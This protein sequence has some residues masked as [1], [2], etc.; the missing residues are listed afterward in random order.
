VGL[1]I[2]VIE[3]ILDEGSARAYAHEGPLIDF[4][5]KHWPRGFEGRQCQ[6]LLNSVPLLVDDFDHPVVAE[7]VV[8]IAFA[9]R[10]PVSSFI[11][12]TAAAA[13]AGSVG[14]QLTIYLIQTVLII[15]ASAL[16]TSLFGQKPPKAQGAARRVYEI[17]AR[18]N[19]PALGDVV[20]EHFGTSWF[21]PTYAAQPYSRFETDQQFIFFI[22]LL[23]AGEIDADEIRIGTTPVGDFPPGVVEYTIFKPADHRSEFGVIEAATGIYEDVIT[24]SEVQ[25]IDLGKSSTEVFF[26]RAFAGDNFYKGNEGSPEI[27]IGDTVTVLGETPTQ[28]NH[29]VVSTVVLGGPTDPN[30]RL[31]RPIVNDAGNPWYQL[32][33]NDDGWRGWFMACPALK[34]TNRI[35][36]DFVFPNGLFI[37]SSEGEFF[38]WDAHVWAEVQLVDEQ[39]NPLAAPQLYKY[40][41]RGRNRNTKRVTEVLYLPTGRYRVRVKREDRDDATQRESSKVLWTALRAFAVNVGGSFAYGDVTLIAMRL[42]ATRALADAATGRITVLGTRV[43]PT[44]ASD[45]ATKARTRNPADAFAQIALAGGDSQGLDM[46]NLKSLS[47]RW[48]G[49]NGFNHRFEDQETVF[50]ALSVCAGNVRATPSAYARQIGMRLDRAQEFDKYLI[51]AQQMLSESYSL[52]FKLR[53]DDN[54]DGYRVEYQDPLSTQTLSVLWPLSAATPEVVRL[55][56]CTDKATALAQAKYLWTKRKSLRRVVD[57][58]TELDAHCFDVG[59]RIA[60][61]H[62][63]VDWVDSARI[64]RIDPTQRILTIDKVLNISGLN[65]CVLRSEL[66]EPSAQIDCLVDR[67]VVTLLTPPPFGIYTPFQGREGTTIAIGTPDN[68]RSAY[69]VQEISP[70]DSTV[71]VKAIG[72]DGAE[73]AFVI[74]GEIDSTVRSDHD[75]PDQVDLEGLDP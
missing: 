41:Y 12:A 67:N 18:Q 54:L 25:E 43:L 58:K 66:G 33:K 55:F 40:F 29:G 36:L 60:V 6:V 10:D 23:G 8:V 45:F 51:T 49:I 70:A 65:V 9:P 20:P 22:M 69:I 13:A 61:L 16:I 5:Q 19:Q 32:V 47:A 11:A 72:Y 50:D 27:V 42:R 37:A 44:V 15:L 30:Y 3:D 68:F 24:S 39:D 59:D 34:T 52:G 2:A 31:A 57:F 48:G 73:H 35:E 62:P 21:F 74:P 53:D 64:M 75:S 46:V 17:S 26:G 7:D 56:G 1:N 71:A 63:L 14:A 28:L 38:N 4:L